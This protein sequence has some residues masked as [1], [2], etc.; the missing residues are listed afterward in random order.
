MKDYQELDDPLSNLDETN[1]AISST[2]L[3]SFQQIHPPKAQIQR[4]ELR[5]PI[6]ILTRLDYKRHKPNKL[7]VNECQIWRFVPRN[8]FGMVG[9]PLKIFTVLL[10]GT[11]LKLL[12]LGSAWVCEDRHYRH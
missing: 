3:R 8:P 6:Q 5:L 1:L 4:Q 12:A 9:L 10:R 2:S 11:R 7:E